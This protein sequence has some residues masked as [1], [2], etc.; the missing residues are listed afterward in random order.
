MFQVFRD[1]ISS[2]KHFFGCLLLIVS[3]Y[4][5][6]ICEGRSE[7]YQIT[8][9]ILQTPWEITSTSYDPISILPETHPTIFI[10]PPIVGDTPLDTGLAIGLCLNGFKAKVLNV[11]KEIPTQEEVENLSVHDDALVR[12]QA[13]II[14]AIDRSLEEENSNGEFA[15]IGASYGGI[16]SAYIA[17]VEPSISASVLIASAG[18]IP[19]VL[20]YSEQSKIKELREKRMV[21][22]GVSDINGYQE[23]MTPFIFL[24]PLTVTSKIPA[25][26]SFLIM[27][28][29]DQE[30]PFR[31]QEQ[32]RNS[33]SSP[34]TLILDRGH[35]E[36]IAEASTIHVGKIIDFL[37]RELNAPILINR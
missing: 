25:W 7:K 29:N 12:G 21:F 8:D 37:K 20:A 32:L 22:H 6:A 5:W 17:G 30:V 31:F 23:L 19:G 13:A 26:S 1:S 3:S 36:G 14:G 24:D 2:M 27:M 10:L 11:V 35:V 15:I 9:P 34:Q 16:L 4:T 33:I 28:K 18:N